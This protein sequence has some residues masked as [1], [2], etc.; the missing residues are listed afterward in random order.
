MLAALTTLALFLAW[1]AIGLAVLVV[2]RAD[3]RVL[4]VALTAPILGTALTLIPLFV[5]SNAGVPL[6]P[7]A[8]P[9]LA[10][11]LIGSLGVLA[12]RRPPL[13]LAVVPVALLCLVELALL[14][15][16]MFEFGFDWLA[17]A[18]GDAGL[19]IL[20]ATELMHHGLQ[21]A[22]DVHALANNRDYATAS[23]TPSLRGL[24]PGTQIGLAGVATV[25]RRP[26][27][28]VYMPMTIAIAMCGVCA[29]GALALQASRRW[30]SASI[31]AALLVASPLAAYGVVQQL[32][33]QVWGLGLAVGLFAWL[34]RS[35]LYRK[36]GPDRLDLFIIS[37]LAA[38]LLIVAYEVATSFALGYALYIALLVVRRR[39]SPRALGVLWGVPLVAIVLVFNTF[40]PLAVAYIR[41]VVLPVATTGYKAEA[42]LFGYAIVPTAIPGIAGVRELFAGP[43]TADMEFYIALSA[44][45]LAGVLAAC[46]IS[47]FTGAAAGIILL[48][49]LALGI[50]LA[51]TG[52]SFGLFKLYMYLQPFLAATV[53]VTISEIRSRRTAVAVAAVVLVVVGLQLQT[54]NAY[55]NQSRNPID[56]R[57]AS[58]QDLLPKFRRVLASAKTPVVSI[59]DNDDLEEL[60]GASVGDKS[61]YFLSRNIFGFAWTT[62]TFS[63]PSESDDTRLTFDEN[64]SASRVLSA[65]SCLVLIPTGS[66]VPFNRRSLPEGSPTLAPA[67]CADIKNILAFVVSSRGQPATLPL[68][69]HEVS[70]WQLVA[71]PSFP[72]R[73]FSGFGRYALFEVLGATPTVRVVLDFTVSPLQTSTGILSLPPAAVVGVGRRLFPVVGSGSARVVSP[74]LRPRIIDG[75][76]YIVIDMGTKGQVPVVRRPGL[77][78]VWGKSV[79]LDQQMLTSYVRDVSLVTSAEYSRFRPP[80]AISNFPTDLENP[81][82]EYSG[83]Y[84]DGWVGQTAYA[85]LSGGPSGDLVVD[86]LVV[87]R[88]GG[89]RLSVVVNGRQVVSRDVKPGL[90]HVDI[91]LPA[92]SGRRQVLLRWRGVARLSARDRRMVAAHLTFL[93]LVEPPLAVHLSSA[94]LINPGV[95]ESGIFDDGWVQKSARVELAGGGPS[96]LVFRA[97]VDTTG[98]RLAL[99]VDGRA[100]L[101]RAVRPG[102]VRIEAPLS[103]SRAPRTVELRWGKTT[104]I[105]PIDPRLAAA[106]LQSIA[107]V[108]R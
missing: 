5:L 59:T 95:I 106:R 99:L 3:T 80:R 56:L 29:T 96:R 27:V 30:W 78:D 97:L 69:A 8:W 87:P 15:R 36:P 88:T 7:A 20:S 32:L 12:L 2:L 47:A 6:D 24:R 17:N 42:S 85:D 75:R 102:E 103:A 105:S 40:L 104:R 64:V 45:L 31:A 101:S 21:S 76:P 91:P 16:P 74:P 34:M 55:V 71:D 44:L 79:T 28:E 1:C 68:N 48:G 63:V 35:E 67:R 46:V 108:S 84:E 41:R 70:Y 62:R 93:G 81:D 43:Q 19:Y 58:S 86:A 11:L 18:N 94:G 51:R 65:R 72:G 9:V 77:T 4:R 26:P 60:E 50:Q 98:Q 33:P 52:N 57:D 49:D 22:M 89:Q 100:V 61:L 90:L 37:A 39:V 82:L 54:L 83:I 107:I 13:P 92:D 38:A 66:E 23:Q 25:I 73:T 53:A 14:G 10:A